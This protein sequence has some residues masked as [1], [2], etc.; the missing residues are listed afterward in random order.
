MLRHIEK[1]LASYE[2]EKWP[3]KREREKRV[4]DV[5]MAIQLFDSDLEI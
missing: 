2:A 1:K 4:M 5:R 3:M